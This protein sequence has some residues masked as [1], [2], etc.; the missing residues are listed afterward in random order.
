MS[1]SIQVEAAAL[2][3]KDAKAVGSMLKAAAQAATGATATVKIVEQ[4]DQE[5]LVDELVQLELK[6][7][8][9]D[10]KDVVKRM[11]EIK[12]ELQS[13][14]ETFADDEPVVFTGS[15]GCVEFSAKANLTKVELP[16]APTLLKKLVKKFGA[17]AAYDTVA[18][19]LTKL[20]KLLSENELSEFTTIMK[21][22]RIS[23][24]KPT[25]SND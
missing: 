25:K 23:K 3:K 17:D 8:S 9:V 6:M 18:F 11:T 20:K 2:T 16:D 7:Q 1:L 21:G 24:I 4:T 19:S 22:S 15:L 14:A 12:K 10:M 13:I 5:M